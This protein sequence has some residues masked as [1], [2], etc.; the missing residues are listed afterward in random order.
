MLRAK[1]L[2]AS[3]RLSR[4]GLSRFLFEE[5][6]LL[7]KEAY[8]LNVGAGGEIQRIVDDLAAKRGVRVVSSDVDSARFPDVVDDITQSS[9]PSE[10][11]DAVIIMEVL[12]HVPEPHR[13]AFEIHRLLKPRGRLI[14]STPF[15][16]PLHD[17]PHDYFRYTKCGLSYLF[18]DFDDLEIRE[19]NS[20]AEA[21][22][23]LIARLPM[24]R[25][26]AFKLASPFF[27]LTAYLLSPLAIL[28]AAIFPSD[29]FTTG[30]VVS[31]LKRPTTVIDA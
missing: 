2:R 3:K 15:V 10:T 25:G 4:K 26:R 6:M 7:E 17:R 11:F 31:G 22:L 19:R 23:V 27:V 13:A 14:A 16:F 18:R 28:A 24:E 1:L 12:E 8:V 29:F 21:L 9:F 20:W 30:Y 5:M